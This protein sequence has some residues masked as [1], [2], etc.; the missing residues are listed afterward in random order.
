[1][2]MRLIATLL[3]PGLLLAGCVSVSVHETRAASDP[4]GEDPAAWRDLER[5]ILANQTQLTFPDRFAKAG[6]AYFSPE[7]RRIVFQAVE[8][9]PAGEKPGEY[10]AMYVADLR[11]GAGG[12]IEG[13]ERVRRLSP[14]G[15]FNTCGW[16]HPRDPDLL[17]FASTLVRP[18]GGSPGYQRGSHDY[19]WRFPPEMDIFEC[20][21]ARADGTAATLHPLVTN[22]QAYLAECSLSPDGRHLLYCSMETGGGDLFVR[23]LTTDR[24]VRLVG[25]PGYDGGPFFS[26]DG[27]RICYR[28]DRR[29]DDLLQIFIGHLTF[30]ADGG[31]SGLEREYQVTDNGQ[32]NFAP[33]WHPGGRFVVYVSSELGHR[34]YEVFVVDADPGDLPGAPGPVRYGTRKRRVTGAEGFDGFPAF[35]AGGSRM[36][37]TSQRDGSKS[38]VWVADFVMDLDAPPAAPR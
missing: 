18:A 9:P 31:I 14:E 2:V 15:S 12:V 10:Y 36:I 33:F 25:D 35:D 1:M 7:G 11:F 38:Q 29:G 13:I 21:L 5:S 8:A 6:E 22:P 32:V 24:T 30:E 3:P 28:S 34:N 20:S 16:F 19:R 23:D 26:P 17:I 27:R 37:W 4:A